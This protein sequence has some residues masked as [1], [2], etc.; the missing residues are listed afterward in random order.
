MNH[1]TGFNYVP[2]NYAHTHFYDYIES[3]PNLEVGESM[4]SEQNKTLAKLRH[5]YLNEDQSENK[6]CL[7]N[8]FKRQERSEVELCLQHNCNNTD[9]F[10]AAD[11]LGYLKKPTA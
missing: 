8:C 2:R 11:I 5:Q 7:R 4:A 10:K 6:I 1:T 9:F 3:F